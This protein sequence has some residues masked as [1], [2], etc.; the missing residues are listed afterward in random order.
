MKTLLVPTDLS[1][2][3]EA[4]VNFAVS[5][6]Q[7]EKAEIILLHVFRLKIVFPDESG[8]VDPK[9]AFEEQETVN[10]MMVKRCKQ[11]T[12][13]KKV[14]CRYINT[15]GLAVDEIL[16][17]E[18][19]IKPDFIVMGTKGASGAK[20]VILG[21]N[22]AKVIE[23]STCPVIAVPE[24]V[25]FGGIKK[26]TYAAD[27][28]AADI[29]AI[30]KLV[31]IAKPFR[32]SIN[33]L[34]IASG[35]LLKAVEEPLM[36]EFTAK[37]KRKVDYSNIS[38]QLIFGKNVEKELEKYVRSHSTDLLAMSTVHRNFLEKLFGSSVTKRMAYHA[39]I[40]LLAFHHKRE[41]VLFI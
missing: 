28:H 41:A 2:A 6:A 1:K 40:P 21:S 36:Q 32:A 31:E 15:M 11:I 17:A 30:R 29:S 27:Y 24:G 26:L 13:S 3:A 4:A 33:V 34:H 22:A 25:K 18:E 35:E 23:K 14:K 19:K 8:E 37:V 12:D 10:K 20:K 39:D 16:A 9:F 38:F 5:F 7:K